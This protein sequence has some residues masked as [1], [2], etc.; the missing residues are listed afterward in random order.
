MILEIILLSSVLLNVVFVLYSRYL[1][2][3]L[4]EISLDLTIL[5]DVMAAYKSS[6]TQV[7]ESELFYGEPTLEQLVEHTKAVS[8]DIDEIFNQYDFEEVD[9]ERKE[10][11]Q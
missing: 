7:Y 8:L 4:K 5:R 10:P 1:I 11:E 6:L 2:V 9:T 3:Q